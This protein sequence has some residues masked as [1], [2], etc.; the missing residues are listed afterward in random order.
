MP[1][2]VCK[3]YVDDVERECAELL[4]HV[5]DIVP[6]HKS[7]LMGFKNGWVAGRGAM[8]DGRRE[9]QAGCRPR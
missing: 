4:K 3:Q 8:L 2:G 9:L 6:C 5:G 1:E 7:F